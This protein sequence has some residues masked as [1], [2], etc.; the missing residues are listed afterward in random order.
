MR[1]PGRQDRERLIRI[2]DRGRNTA[3]QGR[4]R[5]AFS[6]AGR[7]IEDLERKGI[8]EGLRKIWADV[9]DIYGMLRDS[10][11]GRY[12]VPFRSLAAIAV[13]LL[14]LANP[15]DLIPDFIPG[16]GFIDDVF[17]VTLCV[18]FIGT[19]LDRYRSWKH[20]EGARAD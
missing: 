14:Y 12:E 10:I 15:F 1:E 18:K 13:T 19:D 7:M 5:Q 17:I 11:T 16:I 20:G 2:F 9:R 6:R 4:I 3:D 8:P